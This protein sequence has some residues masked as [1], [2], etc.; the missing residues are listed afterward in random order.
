MFAA[1]SSQADS[2]K[3][4]PSQ[5]KA[6]GSSRRW[7]SAG[8]VNGVLRWPHSKRSV[9]RRFAIITKPSRC[10][11]RAISATT[12]AAGSCRE[13]HLE[14]PED[15]AALG[16]RRQHRPLVRAE[17]AQVGLA[18]RQDPQLLGPQRLLDRAAVEGHQDR[19]LLVV[20]PV[21][22]RVV[23][24][25]VRLRHDDVR[26]ADERAAGQVGDEERHR[27]RP[28][29]RPSSRVTASTASTGEAAS[30]VSSIR[31][32]AWPRRA[33]SVTPGA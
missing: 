10:A 3:E 6:A 15:L 7:I 9:W 23:M 8:R 29:R 24:P 27:H 21:A 25:G 30:A 2:V 11:V 33:L 26:Q 22:D 19:R 28:R 13:R 14:Q 4:P 12:S 16:H 1:G 32:T 31:L 5:V 20:P 18:G 17:T